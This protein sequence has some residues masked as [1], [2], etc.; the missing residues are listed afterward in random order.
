MEYEYN[1]RKQIW[2]L[3]IPGKP[4][5]NSEEA[6]KKT[7]RLKQA[8]KESVEQKKLLHLIKKKAV[9]AVKK[10]ADKDGKDEAK[11]E[12]VNIPQVGLLT[13]CT[14]IV[15]NCEQRHG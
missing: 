12:D 10:E 8:E 4:L 7:N 13:S 1:F 11:E 9:K 5:P 3:R 6:K 15:K 2:S 14:V